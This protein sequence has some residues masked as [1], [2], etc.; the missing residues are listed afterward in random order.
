VV[1]GFAVVRSASLV[2]DICRVCISSVEI[3][4]IACGALQRALGMG[5]QVKR[6][7]GES[8]PHRL[9]G[10]TGL[11]IPVVIV[12]CICMVPAFVTG[13]SRFGTVGCSPGPFLT[14]VGCAALVV[15]VCRWVL[16]GFP[17]GPVAGP[18]L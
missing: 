9:Y 14:I 15:V 17:I 3:G 13:A 7:R 8:V 5:V 10:V 2:P 12:S 1:P 4:P 18:T 11:R 16:L 6:F